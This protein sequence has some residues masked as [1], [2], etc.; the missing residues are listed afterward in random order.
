MQCSLV[1]HGFI[2]CASFTDRIYRELRGKPVVET[3]HLALHN[4]IF[5]QQQQRQQHQGT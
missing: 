3:L 4:V 1:I 5:Y 2:I